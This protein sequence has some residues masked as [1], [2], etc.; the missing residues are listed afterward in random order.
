MDLKSKRE[1]LKQI[2]VRKGSMIIAFSGGVDSSLLAVLAKE[3][4][5]DKSRCIL[6]DSPVVPREAIKEAQKIVKDFGL[7]LEIIPISLM[8]DE[9]FRTNP[10][11]RCYYCKKKS[12]GLLKQRMHELGFAC[13]ADGMN[14]SDV[15]EYR[16]GLA[17]STEEGIEHP[18]IEAG[19]TKTDIRN[20]AR[21][22]GLYFWDKPSAA[23][24][25]SRIPYG[26]E[27]T[28]DNLRL[29]EEAE[30]FLHKKGFRQVRVRSH[31]NIARIEVMKEDIPK[32]LSI[33]D[34]VTT[35]LKK[36]GFVYVTLDL[37]GYRSGSMDKML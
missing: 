22:S 5:C 14:V 26:V 19:I 3:T 4:L 33:Q 7:T 18:F 25:S 36:L 35:A 24:L 8:E 13:V 15:D 29:I 31:N 16:P 37:E 23:C 2:I 10:S 20:I 12:A 32:L 17:A 30:E 6:L 9:R 34:K 28:S 27:I 1:Y 21:E 11:E